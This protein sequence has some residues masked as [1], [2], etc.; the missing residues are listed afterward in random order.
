MKT[1]YRVL[2]RLKISQLCSAPN[3]QW[4]IGRS[5]AVRAAVTNLARRRFGS[6][7]RYLTALPTV[8]SFTVLSS[9]GRDPAALP[10]SLPSTGRDSTVY[11]LGRHVPGRGPWIGS[12]A[13]WGRAGAAVVAVGCG[14]CEEPDRISGERLGARDGRGAREPTDG[15]C[16]VDGFRVGAG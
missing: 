12:L 5:M 1:L 4:V 3:R 7:N 16:A 15:F 13:R 10:A 6:I 9:T 14:V 8:L 2:A 11:V